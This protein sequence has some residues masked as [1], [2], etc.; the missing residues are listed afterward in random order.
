MIKKV[1]FEVVLEKD[2][3]CLTAEIFSPSVMHCQGCGASVSLLDGRFCQYCGT[4]IDLEK[5][6][7]AIKEL[8]IYRD[9]FR[10]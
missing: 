8:K 6:D 1:Y 2:E 4:E 9:K 3:K 7:W 10:M 5:Y